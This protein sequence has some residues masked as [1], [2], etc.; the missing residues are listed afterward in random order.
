MDHFSLAVETAQSA[1]AAGRIGTP[2]SM[3]VFAQT[4]GDT[5]QLVGILARS[6]ETASRW[7]AAEL[8]SV[9]AVGSLHGDETPGSSDPAN[10]PHIALGVRFAN[11]RAAVFSAGL[12]HTTP[13][14]ELLVIGNRGVLSW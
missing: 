12:A 13:R 7:L 3:R 11:G 10:T 9:Y 1:L 8:A 14:M 6:L 2:V 4:A 5:S